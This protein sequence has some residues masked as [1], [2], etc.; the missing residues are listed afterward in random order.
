MTPSFRSLSNKPTVVT[1]SLLA[2]DELLL[3]DE[4]A[5]DLLFFFF[6]F[7]DLPILLAFLRNLLLW[8]PSGSRPVLSKSNL[9]GF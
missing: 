5:L 3:L 1:G 9:G 8:R 6:D 2:E 7:L 4:E